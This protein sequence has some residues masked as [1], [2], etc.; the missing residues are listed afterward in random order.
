[1]ILGF[2]TM[3][4]GA[5][6]LPCA[7]FVPEGWRTAWILGT[8]AL[9]WMGGP[10]FIVNASPFLAGSCGDEERS[11][12]FSV[13]SAAFP[14]SGFAGGLIW[15]GLPALFAE[16]LGVSLNSA[17]P[18]RYPL[19]LAAAVYI[20]GL[21]IL[22]ATQGDG[23]GEG[24]EARGSA[25]PAPIGVIL[26]LGFVALLRMT[27]AGAVQSFFNVYLDSELRLAPAT[28]GTVMATGQLLGGV[29]ALGA[30]LLMER[31]GKHST[32]VASSLG[33]AVCH[34]PLAF[35][36]HWLVA[37]GGFLGLTAC[38]SI[39]RPTVNVYGQEAVEPRWRT[40]VSGAATTAM[41]LGYALAGLAGGSM[42]T[43]VGYSPFFA[44][45]AALPAAGGLL[46]WGYFRARH[47]EPRHVGGQQMIE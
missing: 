15:G 8:N 1:M 32:Y 22:L 10:L 45:A 41:G 35:V 27:A 43:H 44:L 4:V 26:V 47:E 36:S 20:P 39:A 29:A 25:A 12:A 40:A 21:A 17:A 23:P 13:F 9:S 31:M 16:N 18:F 30:P 46:F 5:G 2:V 7:E 24:R 42:I 3:P 28:I 14:F 19:W 6:L 33:T 11:Y 38:G 37:A 34:L